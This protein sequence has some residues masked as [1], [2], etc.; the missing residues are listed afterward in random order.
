MIA[1]INQWYKPLPPSTYKIIIKFIDSGLGQFKILKL[2][3]DGI[4]KLP[5]YFSNTWNVK[6]SDRSITFLSNFDSSISRSFGVTNIT[7]TIGS[8]ND[9]KSV[10]RDI[11]S[12]RAKIVDVTERFIEKAS[13]LTFDMLNLVELVARCASV[14]I[15]PSKIAFSIV[16][17]SLIETLVNIKRNICV[18]HNSYKKPITLLFYSKIYATEKRHEAMIAVVKKIF[19]LISIILGVTLVSYTGTMLAFSLANI[20]ATFW[21][22][23]YHET[24]LE[25][26]RNNR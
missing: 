10:V 12:P 23:Y 20:I 11:F 1:S 9:V 4:C 24:M 7:K 19:S 18:I 13:E 22:H 2:I 21:Q 17:A 25:T 26:L 15:F 8:F 16:A 6:L 14:S 5:L 3:G